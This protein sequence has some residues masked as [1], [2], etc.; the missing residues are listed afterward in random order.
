MSPLEPIEPIL[1]S[2]LS[3]PLM[4]QRTIATELLDTI[5]QTNNAASGMLLANMERYG[6]LN[7]QFVNEHFNFLT[8]LN[9]TPKTLLK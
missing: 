2:P 3:H 8:G 5:Q 4:K 7:K 6:R 1:E 9:N